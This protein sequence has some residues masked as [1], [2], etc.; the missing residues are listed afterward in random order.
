M[1]AYLEMV[2]SV[3][4]DGIHSWKTFEGKVTCLILNKKADIVTLSYEIQNAN[5]C[6]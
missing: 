3:N 1:F 4:M 6:I 5:F 2:K